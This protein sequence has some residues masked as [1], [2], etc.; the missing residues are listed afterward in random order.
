MIDHTA[1][2]TERLVDTL[3]RDDNHKLNWRRQATISIDEEGRCIIGL[4]GSFLRHSKG[5][6]QGH[7]WDVYPD[8]YQTPEL[9]FMALLEADPPHWMIK[10]PIRSATHDHPPDA[11]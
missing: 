9:A 5:P 6:R 2:T 1:F 11:A 4:G 7:F 3:L 8:D 10:E